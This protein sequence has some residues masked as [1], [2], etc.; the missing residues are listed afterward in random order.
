MK[1]NQDVIDA[2]NKAL[3]IE[4]AA[5][6]QYFVQSKMCKN[7]GYQK[8]AKKHYQESLGEMKHAEALIDRVL[9]L[10]GTPGL[11][12]M[13]QIRVGS[14][15]KEQLE[16]DLAL[17]TRG[18]N[19]YNE[20]IDLCNRVKDAGSREIMEK[21]LEDSEEHVDWLESQLSVIKDTGI[22]NYLAQHIGE[23]E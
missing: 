12:G 9:F 5:I 6:S 22:E 13:E 17:E 16:N 8:L 18:V 15:V 20:S 14:S 10:E 3:A 7:W 1:G 23:P 19:V 11:T 4:L 2:L 21:I